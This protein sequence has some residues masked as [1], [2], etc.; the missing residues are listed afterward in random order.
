MK[1]EESPIPGPASKVLLIS[2]LALM[3]L[4]FMYCDNVPL[5]VSSKLFIGTER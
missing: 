2:F 4:F 5:A 1:Q 3:T